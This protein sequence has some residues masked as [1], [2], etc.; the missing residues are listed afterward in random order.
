MF[1][2]VSLLAIAFAIFRPFGITLD[3]YGY[4]IKYDHLCPIAECGKWIQSSRDCLW[5]TLVGLLLSWY[6]DPKVMLWLAGFALS[7]KLLIIADI[8][9]FKT[10]ALGVYL[11]VFYVVDDLTALR[12][13]FALS[14][15]YLG[16][17]LLIRGRYILAAPA[18]L[19]P[20]FAHAQAIVAPLF[21][22]GRWMPDGRLFFMAAILAP[23][24]L[25]VIGAVPERGLFAAILSADELRRLLGL[26]MNAD[27]LDVVAG[28]FLGQPGPR[29]PV[30][31]VFAPIALLIVM[32]L[33]IQASKPFG[34]LIRCAKY[35]LV[36]SAWS[37]WL[38]SFNDTVQYRMFVLFFMA[39]IPIVGN[40]APD[41]RWVALSVLLAAVFVVK[42]HV[43]HRLLSDRHHL[44]VEKHG[45]GRVYA[46]G[47]AIDCGEKCETDW[48]LVTEEN[49]AYSLTLYLDMPPDSRVI[50]GGDCDVSPSICYMRMDRDKKA[51]IDFVKTHK[52]K[53]EKVGKGSVVTIGGGIDCGV[54][55][56]Y[57][58]DE[59]SLV[60]FKATPDKG[61]EF[62]GWQGGCVG[63]NKI[64]E[65]SITKD[66][67][68]A[69]HFMPV[70][71]LQVKK[72]GQ[73][74]VV[75]EDGSIDCGQSCGTSRTGE[76]LMMH[77]RALPDPGYVFKSW[78]GICSGTEPRC[79]FVLNSNATL[80]ANFE[81]TD[82]GSPPIQIMSQ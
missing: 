53:L 55:C 11:A 63:E 42:Y 80:E 35:G 5:F 45:Q 49:H 10:L 44:V 38:F 17:W 15:V 43:L 40:I 62:V 81:L 68:V 37:L 19:L 34:M 25:L 71:Q 74:R 32:Y 73:G 27:V 57:P 7:L 61:Y 23:L 82:V 9:R 79:D 13:G 30:Y 33:V 67:D 77:L 2:L 4:F 51:V 78:S 76:G 46:S 47:G 12:I 21:Y 64:C 66:F 39:A 3:D 1:L 20:G 65:L 24:G 59:D 22:F 8:T 31:P 60:K 70:Y 41:I 69:A 29:K 28:E 26:F 14:F 54:K 72:M 75:S 50:M 36:L 6:Q 48:G 58:F 16:F 56:E 52:A 18:F